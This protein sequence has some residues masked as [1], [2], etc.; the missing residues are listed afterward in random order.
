MNPCERGLLYISIGFLV[1]GYHFYY[2]IFFDIGIGVLIGTGL[3]QVLPKGF[4]NDYI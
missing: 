2:D 1:F 4:F 3:S